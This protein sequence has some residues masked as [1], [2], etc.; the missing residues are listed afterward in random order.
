[1]PAPYISLNGSKIAPFKYDSNPPYGAFINTTK[2]GSYPV[3]QVVEFTNGTSFSFVWPSSEH[4]FHA[5]K[6]IH[7][8]KKNISNA[9]VQQILMDTLR[10]IEST[11]AI[12]GEEFLPRDDWDPIVIELTQN[13]PHLFG[14]DKR[15]FD[16]L[17]DS[18]YHSVG[19]PNAGLMPNGEP[20][21]L[22]FM[23]EVVKLKL[24][25]CPGLKQL[26]IDC[27]REAILPIEVSQ[28]DVNWASGRDGNGAN[29]LGI[30]ILEL[31]NKFYRKKSRIPFPKLLILKIIISS[32]KGKTLSNYPTLL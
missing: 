7:L 4:A 17:C 18:N 26:A 13:H 12:A 32:C 9:Q 15:A 28:Y 21:T 29:M 14:R 30:V 2:A 5:Q 23:R 25:Q 31:G 24:E 27:A 8:M 3:K 1:M 16:A 11:K 10:R 20:Y 6:I 19:N 22:S